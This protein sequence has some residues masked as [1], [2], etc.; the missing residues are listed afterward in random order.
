MNRILA[1]DPTPRGFGFALLEDRPLR[2]IDWG[3]VECRRGNKEENRGKRLRGLFQEYDPSIFVIEDCG[4]KTSRRGH[5]TRR[6]ADEIRLLAQ[7]VHLP[8]K[9]FS[10]EQ[11]KQAFAL[12]G[13]TTKQQIAQVLADGFPELKPRLPTVREI[14][15]SEDYRISIFDAVAL[16]MTF[17][18]NEGSLESVGA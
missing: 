7:R 10:R 18:A 12:H 16:G 17:V 3:V 4:R 8:L 13:A 14:W 5:A 15:Q 2:L 6:F 1:I 11:V 9:K